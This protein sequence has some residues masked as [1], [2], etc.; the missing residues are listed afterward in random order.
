MNIENYNPSIPHTQ[1]EIRGNWEMVKFGIDLSQLHVMNPDLI[2]CKPGIFVIKDKNALLNYPFNFN[3]IPKHF[4][5][6]GEDRKKQIKFNGSYLGIFCSNNNLEYFVTISAFDSVEKYE[7]SKITCCYST[8]SGQPMIIDY[9]YPDNLGTIAR[10]IGIRMIECQIE[11]LLMQD[12]FIVKINSHYV[13]NGRRFLQQIS[14]HKFD[15]IDALKVHIKNG[16]TLSNLIK[17]T[18]YNMLSDKQKPFGK[19]WDENVKK[20]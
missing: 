4:Q 3:F 18:F 16:K 7:D 6:F 11:H 19:K 12:E 10:Y 15:C 9:K 5:V 17:N 8:H 1:I 13:Q 14:L 20:T 2:F